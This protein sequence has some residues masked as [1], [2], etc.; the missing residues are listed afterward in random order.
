MT[1]PCRVP[2]VV[3]ST[4]R[5]GN[6]QHAA[7]LEGCFLARCLDMPRKRKEPTNAGFYIRSDYQNGDYHNR[8]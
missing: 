6:S 8:Y 1:P 3:V 4:P 2:L 7:S 5:R